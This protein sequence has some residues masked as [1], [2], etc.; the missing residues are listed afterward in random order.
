MKKTKPTRAIPTTGAERPRCATARVDTD[1]STDVNLETNTLEPSLPEDRS[2][3]E[4]LKDEQSD[5]DEKEPE[6]AFPSTD[7]KKS[8]CKELRDGGDRSRCK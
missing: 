6:A 3:K 5:V 8:S 1:E 4:A 2:D 7:M